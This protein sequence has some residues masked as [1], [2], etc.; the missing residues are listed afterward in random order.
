VAADAAAISAICIRLA[1][2]PDRRYSIPIG[3]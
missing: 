2:A 3:A 1:Y